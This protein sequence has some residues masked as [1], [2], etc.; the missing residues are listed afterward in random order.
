[1]KHL[2]FILVLL[3]SLQTTLAQI[4]DSA[5][6]LDQC[7]ALGLQTSNGLKAK[8]LSA[9]SA[10]SE[11]RAYDAQ[12]KPSLSLRGYYNYTSETQSLGSAFPTIPGVTFKDV[13]FGDGNVYDLNA[14]ATIPI[15]S[16]GA[17]VSREQAALADEK[18]IRFDTQA[19]SLTLLL[20]IRRAYFFAAGAQANL[21]AADSR[22][23]RLKRHLDEL[24]SAQSVGM[25]T[26]DTRL[27]IEASL[28][29]AEAVVLQTEA[30]ARNARLQLG[31]LIG[32]PSREVHPLSSV[33]APLMTDALFTVA[34][35]ENRPEIRTLD[36]RI[37]QRDQLRRAG[38]ASL[39]PS[40]AANAVYHY[41]KPGVDAIENEWMDYY[42]L[43]ISASWTV[44]DFSEGRTRARSQKYLA[45]SL[46]ATREDALRVYEV[47][48]NTAEQTRNAARPAE[49]KLR[50]RLE[51]ET[52]RTELTKNKLAA[53]LTTE[54]M[55]L[56]AQDDLT[57][58]E[59]DW[60][61]SIVAL[62]IAEADYLFAIGR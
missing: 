7:I 11:S 61:S 37:E 58:A 34:E 24:S 42:T 6:S 33:E 60:I 50:E 25:S 35:L 22:R 49:Q 48:V 46:Q 39:F 23:E 43:G 40:V 4:P 27:A 52:K 38:L 55:W 59:L 32:E 54:S 29:S 31:R 18:A 62:R 20:S 47:R 41:A 14:S 8:R 5:L 44:W 13:E 12:Q 21:H 17:V 19:D 36:A 45:E 26:E 51:L 9:L 3:T 15:Y 1:M 16:G 56:D 30:A 2:P 10:H 57:A 28:K 53:G